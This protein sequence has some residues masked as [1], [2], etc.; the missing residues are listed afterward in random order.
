M[1]FYAIQLEII[2][3]VLGLGTLIADAFS[4]SLSKKTLGHFLAL[5]VAGLFIYSFTLADLGYT[6]L[7]NGLYIADGLSL[8]LKR[9]F[10]I[11]MSLVLLL[12]AEF[13]DRIES[14]MPEF[15]AITLIAG[16]GMLILTSI[17]DFILLFVGLELITISFY[18]LTSFLRRQT[19]SL[20]AGTKYLILGALSSGFL[21]YGISYVYGNAGTTRFDNLAQQLSI[22][23]LGTGFSFGMLLVLAGLCF[24]IAAVPFQIWAPDVYQGAPTPVTAFL[25][26]GSKAAGFALLLRMTMLGIFPHEVVWAYLFIG[27]SAITL[28]YGN[29]GALPQT[30]FKRLLGY[31]SIGHAGYMLMGIATDSALGAS[32]LLYYLVQYAITNLCIFLALVGV[33]AATH[34]DEIPSLRG[35]YKRSPLLTVS[36]FIGLASLAGLPPLSGFFGKFQLFLAVMERASTLP[37]F[38]ALAFVGAITVVI[39][40]YFYF[41]IARTMYIDEPTDDTPIAVSPALKIGLYTTCILV[42]ALGIFQA[43]L[44][45]ASLKAI[46][47]FL[48]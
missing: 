12:S 39:S 37:I 26:V 16:A 47:S 44:V 17:N 42:V 40:L 41:N 46:E 34:T 43:P 28:L 8:F 35:L 19:A 7:F 11:I 3:V 4:A 29:L 23:S 30:S 21:V 1:N 2:L 32:A 18:I 14:G 45:H 38:Y 13:S 31:S 15:Y 9:L 5:S 48:P 24:K 20:E 33:T 22:G 25:A 10:L 27:L 6:P 36:L